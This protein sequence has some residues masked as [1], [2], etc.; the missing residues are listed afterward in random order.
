LLKYCASSTDHYFNA[1][2][3]GELRE[4]F[5]EIAKQLNNLRLTE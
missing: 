1:N 5:A 2:N 4:A 3:G